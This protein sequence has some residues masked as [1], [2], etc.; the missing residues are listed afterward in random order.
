MNTMEVEV[1]RSEVLAVWNIK[2]TL[3]WDVMSWSSVDR[4]QW[5]RKNL[6]PPSSG[7][8]QNL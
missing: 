6:L 2:I 3:F 7:E 1:I 8:K 5:F 4:Y